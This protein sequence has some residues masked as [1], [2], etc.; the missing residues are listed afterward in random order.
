MKVR[1]TKTERSRGLTFALVL[2]APV[3]LAGC[4]T[5][6]RT[7]FDWGVNTRFARVRT[8]HRVTAAPRHTYVYREDAATPDVVPK[9]RPT[10]A[11]YDGNHRPAE[12]DARNYASPTGDVVFEWPVNGRVISGFGTTADGGR[13]DGINIAATYGEP[14][15]A[16]ASGTVTYA[17]NELKSYGNLVLIR[18]NDGYVTAYAHAERLTVDRGQHVDKGQVI[19]YAGNTGDVSQPQLHFEIRQGVR[20]VNPQTLL[21]ASSS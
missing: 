18:H 2:L 9:P 10:P 12:N 21:V 15:R 13:N 6:P 17:G 3:L 16:A 1:T 5:T 20:P 11:W 7:E 14:I 8:Y 19:G 4:T